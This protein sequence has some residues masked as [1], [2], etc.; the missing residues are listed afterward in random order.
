MKTHSWNTNTFGNSLLTTS[1][2]YF[3]WSWYKDPLLVG[4]VVVTIV[5]SNLCSFVSTNNI[6]RADWQQVKSIFWAST[7]MVLVWRPTLGWE[8]C[9]HNCKSRHL[10]GRHIRPHSSW[11]RWDQIL[12]QHLYFSINVTHVTTQIILLNGT[13]GIVCI[14]SNAMMIISFWWLWSYWISKHLPV[15]L[16]MIFEVFFDIYVF[17]WAGA[18]VMM[19]IFDLTEYPS[20]SQCPCWWSS[21]PQSSTFA[22]ELHDNWTVPPGDNYFQID[23]IKLLHYC[24][25]QLHGNWR[26]TFLRR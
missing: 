7:S 21:H 8:G 22:T 1:Q 12:S 11:L 15:S 23:R 20:I 24:Y 18:H 5:S 4:K 25:P 10:C 16:L 26:I 3:L 13:H 19:T 14:G 6:L 17:V 2:G 9:G